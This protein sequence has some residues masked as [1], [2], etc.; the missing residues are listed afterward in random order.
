MKKI[1]LIPKLINETGGP[2]TFQKRFIEY[3]KLQ[4]YN[5]EIYKIN[6][7]TQKYT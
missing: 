3:L 5:F 6:N 7:D 2:G 4:N 1:L